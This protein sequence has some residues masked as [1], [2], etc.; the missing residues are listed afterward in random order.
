[1]PFSSSFA[2]GTQRSI[3][4]REA[5]R[6]GSLF[7][8]GALLGTSLLPRLV[9]QTSA[10]SSPTSPPSVEDPNHPIAQ[11][12]HG[13]G[14]AQVET[15]RLTDH[16]FALTGH[17]GNIGLFVGEDGLLAVDSG[18][19]QKPATERLRAALRA[20]SERP[21]R[22]VVNTHWHF[23]HTDGNANLHGLGAT[24]I[25]HQKVRERLS[26][27]QVIAFFNATFPVSPRDALPALT[28]DD[29]IEFQGGGEPVIVQHLAPAHTDG[30]SFVHWPKSNI[31]QTGDVYFS[32]TFPFIDA[33]TGGSLAGMIAAGEKILSLA[34]SS[35][36]IIPGHGPISSRDDLKA[37]V[38]M[39]KTVRDRV[40]KLKTSGKSVEEAIAAKPLADLEDRW[41]K[42]FVNGEGFVRI[43]YSLKT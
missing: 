1:M 37:S 13:M 35:T 32:G 4:R 29:G 14:E 16:H 17:G 39:L 2:P 30:D 19:G 42:G 10:A 3:S 6:R 28:F 34:D 43:V 33:S 7:F 8:G 40:G 24:I 27:P 12:R 31:V 25:A 18:S 21:L 11:M 20:I 23:D 41:G 5:L 26:T 9:A 36:R 15:I 38:E 22:N